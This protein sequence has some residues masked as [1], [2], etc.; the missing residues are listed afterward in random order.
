M[1]QFLFHEKPTS[2]FTIKSTLNLL[3]FSIV[4]EKIETIVPY[5]KKRVIVV[6]WYLFIVFFT[7]RSL[8]VVNDALYK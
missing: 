3:L 6:I 8:I 7:I 1:K 5:M 4:I 2:T